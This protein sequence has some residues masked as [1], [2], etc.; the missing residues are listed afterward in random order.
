MKIAKKLGASLTFFAAVAFLFLAC[1]VVGLPIFASAQSANVNSGANAIYNY[2]GNPTQHSTSF[3]DA[4]VFPGTG[5][6]SDVCAKINAVLTSWTTP[7]PPFPWSTSGTVVDAR[8]VG[9]GTPQTCSMN[10]FLGITVPSVVLL[11]PGVITTNATWTPP[12]NTRIIGDGV[13]A[14]GG[15]VL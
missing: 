1:I 15:S 9:T 11:P 5:G 4:S 12:S 2:A 7:P 6:N 13:P 3:V 8:G 14:A 10:P